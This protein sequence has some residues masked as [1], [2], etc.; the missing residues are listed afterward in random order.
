M[1]D[2]AYVY[3]TVE[4]GPA[5]PVPYVNN[6][7]QWR[8]QESATETKTT[9]GG[10]GEPAPA[11]GGFVM[12]QKWEALPE[13]R[14]PFL[15]SIALGMELD[16]QFTPVVRF[17]LGD[18]SRALGR[19]TN[20]AWYWSEQDGH[21]QDLAH[22][23][24]WVSDGKTDYFAPFARPNTPYDFKLRL[25]L[26]R[27]L[28]TAWVSRRGD[29]DWFLLAEDVPLHTEA[30]LINLVRTELYPDAPPINRLLV[31]SSPWEPGEQILPHPLAKKDRTVGPDQSFT[32]QSM[33]STWRKPGRH[34]T[35]FREPGVHAAFPDIAQAGSDHLVCVWRNGS[36]TGGTGG[37]SIA[38]SHDLGKTWN[39]P[40]LA[41]SIQGNCPRLQRLKD[42]TLLLIVDVSSGG[43]ESTAA[44]DLV[45]WD[46][47][48]GGETWINERRINPGKAGGGGFLVPSRVC[49]LADG[50]WLLA[51]CCFKRLE[52]SQSITVLDY[53]RSTDRGRTWQFLG[54]PDNSPH[55]LCEPSPVQLPDGK[56]LVFARETRVD[57]MP[58]AKGY[59][60]DGGMTWHY[61][62]LPHPVIGRTCAGLL[63]DGRIMNTFRSG[64]ARAALW[65]WIGSPDDPTASQP[66]GSHFNDSH[67]VGLK[68]GAL[69]IDNDGLCGQF[70]KYRLHPAETDQSTV[71]L[72]FEVKVLSNQGRAATVS[73][74]FAGKLRLFPDHVVMAHDPS[75]RV[76]VKPG[77]F[78]VYRVV[79]HLGRM[80]IHVDGKIQLDTDKCD[81][82]LDQQSWRKSPISVYA[83]EFG[84][85][86]RGR[87]A[88]GVEAVGTAG[89]DIYAANITA[90][91]T[92]YS[93]WRRFECVLDDPKT[94][95][96]VLSWTAEKDGFPDQYQLDHIIEIDASVNGHEQGYSGWTQLDDGRIFVVHYT[97]D[98]SAAGVSNPSMFGV[99]WIRGTF[100][101]P[102]DLP[103]H[104]ECRKNKSSQNSGAHLA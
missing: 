54:A 82:L 88:T 95:R 74:P 62:D 92:G 102:E 39:K 13:E 91:V 66:A 99:P 8:P 84:N 100:L 28:M 16:G 9:Q 101:Q 52:N 12:D 40:V 46:S 60:L 61:Q 58:G 90:E 68:D 103:P 32:F 55:S 33:R 42:G 83:L 96:Q 43:D 19:G 97:D 48:D 87:N 24:A 86:R 25:D 89:C 71:D 59:S 53:Y 104:G 56:M 73:I 2:I 77:E 72:T 15:E 50:S 10:N 67:S 44:W 1:K 22:V 29:D 75:L 18:D 93:I 85:E 79:S 76:A 64:V 45:L 34:V 36:H 7:P 21:G 70:T 6:I 14:P 26:K 65:A 47:R 17:G 23:T 11:Q 41:T 38:H 5:N 57:G 31:R 98:T 37:L 20:Q 30:R 27:Q 4:M 49:E 51:A 3:A 94:G 69:H 80:Q 81:G 35:I 78:H 63:R